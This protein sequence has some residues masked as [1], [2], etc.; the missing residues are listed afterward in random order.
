MTKAKSKAAMEAGI[1]ERP[2]RDFVG[3]RML[4]GCP[5]CPDQRETTVE[6]MADRWGR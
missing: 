1:M 5:S 6:A 3:F 4:L 2:V